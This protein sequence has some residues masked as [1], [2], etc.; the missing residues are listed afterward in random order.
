MLWSLFIIYGSLS[1][2]SNIDYGSG[3]EIIFFIT[4]F[5]SFLPTLMICV[6][7]CAGWCQKDVFR[8]RYLNNN[9]LI[10]V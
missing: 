10:F 1:V 6:Y 5:V 4:H 2:T 3:R 8:F 9:F 7:H